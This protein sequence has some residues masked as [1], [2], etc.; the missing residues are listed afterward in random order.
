MSLSSDRN[1]HQDERFYSLF[2]RLAS[3]GLE[4][5]RRFRRLLDDYPNDLQQAVADIRLLEHEADVLV[6]ELES[7]LNFAR[8]TPMDREDIHALAGRLDD[9]VDHIEA[10]VDRL[11]LFRVERTTDHLLRFADALVRCLNE[12]V[13][14]V[15][16]LLSGG[17]D[18]LLGHCHQINEIENQAD[19]ILREA[20]G[21]LFSGDYEPLEV[22]KWKE[23]Y[24]YI[25]MATDAC[26]DVADVLESAAFKGV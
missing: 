7:R 10:T 16:A 17:R 21:I 2:R 14:S 22:I 12:V 23:I 11:L 18:A 4:A 24:D 5:A 19:Q 26:E 15:E 3:K 20:L 1:A 13:A 6:H 9:V 8:V 25:E